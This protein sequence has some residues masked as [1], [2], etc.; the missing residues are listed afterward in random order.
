MGVV[1]LWLM[2]AKVVLITGANAGIGFAS[3][4]AYAKL[5]PKIYVACR[6]QEKA[7]QAI[8]ELKKLSK[9]E[10]IHYLRL[11]LNDL[12]SVDACA[13]EL[14]GKET[15]LDVLINNAGMLPTAIDKRSKQGFEVTFAVNY[16]GHF[17]LTLHLLPLLHKAA[18]SRIVNVS[19]LTHEKGRLDFNTLEY[20]R[21]LMRHNSSIST[22]PLYTCSSA[23]HDLESIYSD[24]KLATK[25]FSNEL[26]DRFSHLGIVSNAL[27]PGIVATNILDDFKWY[28]RIFGPLVMRI[29]GVTPDYAAKTLLLLG[30]DEKYATISGKYFTHQKMKEVGSVSLD[31]I[32]ARRLWEISE[33]LV[34]CSKRV[35]EY[36]NYE[37]LSSS[38]EIT[39]NQPNPSYERGASMSLKS[40]LFMSGLFLGILLYFTLDACL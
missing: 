26:S 29:I 24:S 19:S 3:A 16:L 39:N 15:K 12:D 38:L 21:L 27:C 13:K 31:K 37:K 2:E 40:L 30:V 18:P 22:Y 23:S 7:E 20:W 33:D 1:V 5:N 36:E 35:P 25:L 34:Q 14:K 32:S 6:S 9:N 10:N 11:D 8:T 4:L 28:T 17:L